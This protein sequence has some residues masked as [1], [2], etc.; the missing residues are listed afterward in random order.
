MR[1]GRQALA[2]PAR[3]I[4]RRAQ[5]GDGVLDLIHLFDKM[6]FTWQL[7]PRETGVPDLNGQPAEEKALNA[8]AQPNEERSPRPRRAQPRLVPPIGPD[9]IVSLKHTGR[10]LTNGEG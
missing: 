2:V 1:G 9:G 4:W 10:R 6:G 5:F 3:G 8:S 7:T